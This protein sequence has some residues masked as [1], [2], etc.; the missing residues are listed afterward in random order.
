M[1][2]VTK[3]SLFLT[4]LVFVFC[5]RSPYFVYSFPH[6][7]TIM[8]F[9]FIQMAIWSAVY[10][11]TGATKVPKGEHI[12]GLQGR[13]IHLPTSANT[14]HRRQ[15]SYECNQLSCPSPFI[16]NNGLCT[17]PPIETQLDFSGVG[18]GNFGDT[19]PCST[20]GY[21]LCPNIELCCAPE[22]YCVPADELAN[23]KTDQCV[24][25]AEDTFLCNDGK[26]CCPNGTLCA[27][28]KCFNPD[29]LASLTEDSASKTG[30]PAVPTG[31]KGIAATQKDGAGQ[32]IDDS[33]NLATGEDSP[34]PKNGDTGKNEQESS[35]MGV[36]CVSAWG[37]T[38]FVGAIGLWNV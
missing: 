25:C 12:S 9:P 28:G 15:F 1:H 27:E 21:I 17:A 36:R 31:A 37:L 24:S 23:R 6:L 20:E 35:A 29:A 32:A 16:C 22:E 14:I 19:N 34:A 4:P 10:T 7:S 8:F 5:L 3:R 2:L 38:T 18:S 33:G 30:S 11:T 26:T 13:L